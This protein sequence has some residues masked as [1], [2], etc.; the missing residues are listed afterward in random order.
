MS[1]VALV[2][3]R[4]G[5]KG[6]TRKNLALC[7]D[8]AL[9]DWTAESALKSGAID[10]AIL[11]TDDAEIA[12][13]GRI[14]GLEVPFMRPAEIAGDT[15]PMIDVMRHALAFLR[16]EGGKVEALILLQPTSPFRRAH[17][18]SAAVQRFLETRADTLVSIV[19]VPHRFVPEAQMRREGEGLVP[20]LGGSVG[21]TRRQE[22][23]ILFGRNGPAVLIVRAGVLDAG[24]LYGDFAVGYEMD[25]IDSLDI[26]T[27]ADLELADHL[28]RTGYR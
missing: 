25:E 10:R 23:E 24:A 26:D 12:A 7:G 11:S 15:T 4:G 2:P 18:V 1:L 13:A 9:L 19:R 17:H 5:S 6:I 20:Y 27:P 28:M 22:K 16:G 21:K 3:A 8:R 14:F